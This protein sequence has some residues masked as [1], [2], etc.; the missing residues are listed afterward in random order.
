MLRI[1]LYLLSILLPLQ[2]YARH[3]YQLT[4]KDGLAH[5]SVLAIA[6]DSLGRIWLGTAEGISIY[7]GNRMDTYKPV[8]GE[9]GETLFQGS[10]VNHIVCDKRGDVFF[11]T[12]K[13]L[14]KYDIRKGT[15]H[16]LLKR[17]FFA[18]YSHKGEIW[19]AYE[20]MLYRWDSE[21]CEWQP[22]S[23]HPVGSVYDILMDDEGNKWFATGDGI[24]HSKGNDPFVN[25]IRGKGMRKLLLARDGSLYIGNQGN[26]LFRI[27]PDGTQICYNTGNSWD[28]GLH[29]DQVRELVEDQEGNIWFGTFG[30]IY[31]LDPQKEQFTHYTHDDRAG[32]LSHPSVYSLFISREGIL[33][34]GTY[35]GGAC[36]TSL[37]REAFTCYN[38]S[39]CSQGLSCPVVGNMVQDVRGDI[40]IGTEGGGLNKLHPA[41]RLITQYSSADHSH[42]L[43][44]SHLK[45]LFY[46]PD[47][48][49]LYIGTN[50]NG[51][52]RY[53][54]ATERF[55]PLTG[56]DPSSPLNTVNKIVCRG[57]TLFLSANKSIYTYRLSTGTVS[58]FYQTDMFT[59]TCI[60][61][62]QQ[63][64]VVRNEILYLLSAQTGE[65][66]H[67]YDLNDQG[68]NNKVVQ[69]FCSRNGDIYITTLGNGIMK[70]DAVSNTFQ[71]FPAHHS[72]LL[73]HYCYQIGET[74]EG[75]LA[76]T[77]D[78]G[79]TFI[80]TNGQIER[81]FHIGRGVP[82]DA[83]SK[84]CGLLIG[85]NGNIYVGG[86]NG[87]AV[88]S[89][90]AVKLPDRNP[91]ERLYF[92]RLSVHNYP[93]TPNDESGIL[94]EELPFTTQV[95]L[96]HNANRIEIGFAFNFL[97]HDQ[98]IYEYRLK[99]IDRIWYRTTHTAIAYTNLPPGHYTLEVREAEGQH[100]YPSPTASLRITILHPW[101]DTWW[102]WLIYLCLLLVIARIIYV[103]TRARRRLR[104]SIHKEQME[105]QHIKEVTEAK[106]K[107]FTSVS[108]EFRTPLTLIIGQLELLQNNSLS[109][110]LSNKLTKVIQ[111]CN[112]LNNLV[113]ELIEFRKYELGRNV[114]HV[115]PHLI[116][117]YV[118]E[119]YE[120]F[121]PLAERQDIHF[122]LNC[123]AEDA[124]V[125]F[126]R[127]QMTK[128]IYN[129]L[130]NAFKYT[131]KGGSIHMTVDTGSQPG[132]ILL[133]VT[134]NG[135]GMEEKDLPYIF[136]RFYQADNPLPDQQQSFRAGIGLALAKSIIEEHGGNITVKSQVGQGSTFTIH[137]TQGRAHL[138][139][140]PH[141]VFEQN[142]GSEKVMLP[143]PVLPVEEEV[144]QPTQE[145]NVTGGEEDKPSVILVEDNAELLSIL[146]DI[147]T[148]LYQVRTATDGRQALELI[149]QSQPDLVVSDVM[150]P[151]MNG[152]E[153]CVKIKQNIELCH[154]PVVLLTALNLPQQHLEGLI[155]GADDYV[156]KPFSPQILLARCGNIIRS[157]RM[158]RQQLQYKTEPDL[159]LVATNPL[160]KEF[161]ERV[162][163]LLESRV[164]DQYFGVEQLANEMC[165]G[166]TSFYNK[167]K[168]LT[169]MSPN[170]FIN[171]YKLRQAA[172]WFRK[173]SSLS[174]TE[175]AERLGFNTPN[176]FCRK[177]KEEFGMS[178]TQFKK[179]V[180]EKE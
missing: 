126:D 117:G 69:V 137:F 121:R 26:G 103:M 80:N 147:F 102:A 6:Q 105:K 79:L 62:Q 50:G 165:M 138:E 90:S 18:L 132:Q 37:Y 16:T 157:R 171:R 86:T 4:T 68:I 142:D 55:T 114:L 89:P 88:L 53:D 40:W 46:L 75:T 104:E 133:S 71:R 120:S 49:Q 21:R 162:N 129:L 141:I 97:N 10:L 65:L 8:A 144:T 66:L 131:P 63:L 41:T 135:V 30:G 47:K 24:I 52:F 22:V 149:Q 101:Y 143:Q 176:Y 59:N 140:N 169:G 25:I 125:W 99:G 44:S 173:D 168:A 152:T 107:F 153:L 95:E 145:E 36:Y 19:V 108:H 13:A 43:P 100:V 67:T 31:C 154:I 83:F 178:P 139:N 48:D 150:M 14:V 32:S 76:V 118:T 11:K 54:I 15:F 39:S 61:P 27:M 82:L 91:D 128:V 175:T 96:P 166:R 136:E 177:F 20:Y 170:D 116:N 180:A 113:T 23:K 28:K 7:D 2:A 123:A 119:I 57:D 124:E 159:S 109:P 122:T 106:F 161:L 64:W 94:T 45:S 51:L 60:A 167:F 58:L 151:V 155:K 72:P 29:H 172:V 179:Q 56:Q 110:F 163:A 17:S 35:F 85:N 164:D 134:D 146:Q 73:S 115:S 87:L 12:N 34:A 84:D 93:V 174:I 38:A 92:T 9:N 160:D 158:L 81:S 77:G 127:K 42:W 156:C 3:F 74:A 130:S 5:P 1:I 33:W 78:Q 112:R 70:L 148:P 111:Q 98:H